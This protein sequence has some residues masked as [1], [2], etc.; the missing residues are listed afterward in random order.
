MYGT[1]VQQFI[2]DSYLFLPALVSSSPYSINVIANVCGD[3]YRT[4]SEVWDDG[5]SSSGDGWS[6]SWTLESGYSWTGGTTTTSDVCSEVCGDGKRFTFSAS[7]WDDGNTSDGDGCSSTWSIETGFT[8]SGGSS[9]APDIWSETWGDGKRYS[10]LATFWDDGNTS[11]GDGC[12]ATCSVET[13]WTCSGGTSTTPDT[14]TEVW[15]DGK[16]FNS[17]S[18]YWDDGNT[19]NGDG[20]SLSCSIETGW[21][22]S[23]GTSTTPD[24]W[25]ENWGDGKRFNSLSTYW[26]DGNTS[27]GD[28]CSS[29]WSVEIGFTWSGGSSTAPDVWSETWGDGKRYS[30]LATFWD[31]GNTSNGDGCSSTWSVEIGFTWSGGS[32]TAPDVWSETWGDGKRYSS[33]ATFWDDGNTSNGDGWNS[34]WSIETGWTWSGGTTSTK[35]TWSEIWG[36]GKQFN[37]FSTYWDDGNTSNN[38]G[39]NSSWLIEAGWNWSGGSSTTKNTWTEIW[40]DSKR[41]NTI[42]TYW[43]DGNISSSDGCN[44]TWQVEIGWTWSGGT[45]SSQDTWTEVWGDGKRFNTFSTYWDDGN[46]SNNDGCNSLWLIEAGWNW[47]GGSSTTKDTWTEIWGDGIKFNILT[48]YC[49]DANTL[50][51]D[52]CNSSWNAESGWKWTG[53]STTSADSWYDICGDGINMTPLSSNWDDGNLLNN[54]GWNTNCK[55]EVG[56][57]CLG[58][59]KTSI[60]IWKE[61]WGDGRIFHWYF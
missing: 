49:D 42:S 43:D 7:Y 1:Q 41:F 59:S 44:A 54:D 9:T 3:G 15:G 38:D 12:S 27:N 6:S 56:W 31:D 24:S 55:V 22:C 61:I 47:S 52:G 17:L 30:S 40:G 21:I 57:N 25:S 58:G 39:C 5:N 10:S 11:N 34:S 29:T 37:T 16:R 20:C 28:G 35:D 18:T 60:D 45:T 23:G 2:P 32:S 33:L 48:T 13:G 4:S 8:W 53:G 50:N 19:S 14:W 26:D 36:D 51:G 46:T